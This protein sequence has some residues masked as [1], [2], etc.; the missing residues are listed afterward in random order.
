MTDTGINLNPLSA[1]AEVKADLTDSGN[2]ILN[3]IYDALMGPITARQ[4][5]KAREIETKSRGEASV[6]KA[7]YE[8]QVDVIRAEGQKH[9]EWLYKTDPLR[10]IE[11]ENLGKALDEVVEK[12]KDIPEIE[13]VSDAPLNLDFFNQWRKAAETIDSE[14]LRRIWARLLTEEIKK[15][16]SI[17]PRTLNTILFSSAYERS[18]FIKYSIACVGGTMILNEAGNPLFGN[19]WSDFINIQKAGFV[20]ETELSTQLQSTTPLKK[21]GCT[22]CRLGATNYHI[23]YREDLHF[24]AF[25]LSSAGDELLK[26]I[27]PEKDND[28]LR[29]AAIK[30]AKEVSRQNEDKKIYLGVFL[31]P[32]VS[33]VYWKSHDDFPPI[34]HEVK[35]FQVSP[36]INTNGRG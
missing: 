32:D 27:P 15:E 5:A 3:K 22:V 34:E 10:A 14:E 11:Y 20:T 6:V 28:I 17:S 33:E 24:K 4:R 9:I 16:G 13:P 35:S 7:N 23:F 30:V 31:S 18:L 12:I 1:K 29:D 8:N 26:V 2:K 19:D 36:P 25:I 21:E